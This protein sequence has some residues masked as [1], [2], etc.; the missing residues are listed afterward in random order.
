MNKIYFY[1]IAAL[2]LFLNSCQEADVDNEAKVERK[3]VPTFTASFENFSTRTY[4][5]SDLYMYWT[6]DDRL[7]LFT[8]N[9]YNDQ[10]KFDGRTGDKS[11][12]I[13]KVSSGQWVSVV[14]ETVNRG[15]Y[16]YNASTKLTAD[17]RIN[18]QLPGIQHYVPYSFGVGANT[19][20]AVTSGINDYSLPFKNVCGYLVVKLYGTEKVKK[21]VFEGNNGEKIAGNAIINATHEEDPSV[22]FLGDASSSITIDCGEGV[23]IGKSR[24]SATEF[25][26]VIPPMT[27]EK[28][29]SIRIIGEGIM[30]MKKV[31]TS[32]RTIQRNVVNS[33]PAIETVFSPEG[34]ASLLLSGTD[35]NVAIKSINNSSATQSTVDDVVKRIVF[36]TNSS[37]VSD[38]I[39]SDPTSGEPAYI[40]WDTNT[41]TVIVSTPASFFYL[42]EDASF[43]FCN[44]K[45]LEDIEN[46]MCVNTSRVID[47]T[48]MF[49]AANCDTCYLRTIDL[50]HFDTQ[51]V[52]VFKSMF[53]GQ[54]SLTSLDLSRLDTSSSTDL[55]YMF[56]NCVNIEEI[57]CSGFDTKTVTTMQYMFAFCKKL[58]SV[59]VKS[60]DTR[61]CY[62]YSNMFYHCESLKSLDLSSFD[63]SSG[64][65]MDRMFWYCRSL[66]NISIPNF[67]IDNAIDVR[68]MFNR[69]DSL[70]VLDVSMLNGSHIKNGDKC[71][72]FFYHLLSLRELY[73]G[74]TFMFGCRPTVFFCDSRMPYEERPGSLHGGITIFCTQEI[75]DWFA[76][77]GL[78]WIASG[79]NSAGIPTNHIPVIFKHY[80]TGAVLTVE[81]APN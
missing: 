44:F 45:N 17:G 79:Y 80:E 41:S 56:R 47:M 59:N 69:C 23:T 4:V 64:S 24:E 67:S 28:G 75:A 12:P 63:T 15:V 77:T 14:T 74:S 9:Y 21:L 60:F 76:T 6:A 52:A 25:W 13:S 16:P 2:A 43:M 5:D 48:S 66:K 50:R 3:T 57:D 20:V 27:F 36:Q 39:V 29:F 8:S 49:S 72:Y 19:M 51:N 33:M 62:Y 7:S 22:T 30:Q 40:S 81:W 11:G 1:A 26:F 58:S 68:S 73:C 55:S 53:D 78:R 71:G 37:I 61:R 54:K 38:I 31:T 35:V 65:M 32:T 18:T 34:T 42:P 46:L 70:E 10:Y